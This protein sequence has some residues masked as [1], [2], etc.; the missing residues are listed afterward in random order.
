MCGANNVVNHNDII[1]ECS[2][3]MT[4]YFDMNYLEKNAP[5]LAAVTNS[6]K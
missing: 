6:A 1:L 5:I 4:I 2:F 3:E